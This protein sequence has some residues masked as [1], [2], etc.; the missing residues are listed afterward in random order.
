MSHIVKGVD[1]EG[2]SAKV[3]HPE[4]HVVLGERASLVGE[5]VVDAAELLRDGGGANDGTRHLGVSLDHP[6]VV[7]FTHI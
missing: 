2:L 3:Q 6:R 4:H 1:P 5:E 7:R